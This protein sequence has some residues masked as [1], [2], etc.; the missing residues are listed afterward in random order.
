[1]N[2]T[3]TNE[4]CETIRLALWESLGSLEGVIRHDPELAEDLDAELGAERI[5][6]VL[7]LFE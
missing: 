2:I 5:R 3:L 6:E 4:Q 7:G 1:M